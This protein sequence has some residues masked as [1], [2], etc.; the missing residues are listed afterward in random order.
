MTFLV[1]AGQVWLEGISAT[2]IPLFPQVGDFPKPIPSPPL[3]GGRCPAGTEGGPQ[4]PPQSLRAAS[5]ISPITSSASSSSTSAAVRLVSRA[6]T[7]RVC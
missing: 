4:L 1:F 5:G 6:S 2:L 3:R 7:S